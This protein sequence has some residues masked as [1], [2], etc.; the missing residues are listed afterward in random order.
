M[1]DI[2]VVSRPQ[3][4]SKFYTSFDLFIYI[5]RGIWT[6]TQERYLALDLKAKSIPATKSYEVTDD[7][8]VLNIPIIDVC[9][10]NFVGKL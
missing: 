4:R 7:V 9:K 2:W 10:N 8:S 6:T 5:L 3:S 1:A